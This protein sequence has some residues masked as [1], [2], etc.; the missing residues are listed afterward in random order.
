M[1]SFSQ[2]TIPT[3]ELDAAS[4][5]VVVTGA[6]HVEAPHWATQ[7]SVYDDQG[8]A[9]GNGSPMTESAAVPG[10]YET[11]ISVEEGI[12]DVEASLAGQT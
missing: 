7:I 5:S 4:D 11:A 8:Q 10:V 2:E 3:T 12:Y 6:L 9:V 1:S